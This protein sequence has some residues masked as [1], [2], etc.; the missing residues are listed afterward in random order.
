M[1]RAEQQADGHLAVG[2]VLAQL[3]PSDIKKVAEHYKVF[4][5]NVPASKRVWKI[6]EYTIEE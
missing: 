3:S 1:V 2:Q 4:L 5:S 6:I